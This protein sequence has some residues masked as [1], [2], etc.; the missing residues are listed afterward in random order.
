MAVKQMLSN[1]ASLTLKLKLHKID[2]FDYSNCFRTT[3][4]I[5][6][7]RV[8]VGL[9]SYNRTIKTNARLIAHREPEGRVSPTP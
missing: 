3:T 5:Y 7:G 2:T 8:L 1:A 9:R 4:A 6:S